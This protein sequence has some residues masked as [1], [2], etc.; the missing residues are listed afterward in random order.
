MARILILDDDPLVLTS[1]SDV[2]QSSGHNVSCATSGQE[3][4]EK[5][6]TAREPFDLVVADVRMSGMDGLQCIHELN[7]RQPHLKSIVITGYASD[8]APG[9]AMDASSSDYLRKPFTAEQLLQSVSR[10]LSAG[11]EESGYQR[12]L[13]QVRAVAQ[14]VGATLSGMEAV[15]DRVFQ[16]YYLGIRAGHLRPS[17]ARSIWEWLEATEWER[18]NAEQDLSLVSKARELKESYEKVGFFCKSPEVVAP[19]QG[20]KEQALSQRE[21]QP[22]YKNIQEGQI[23]CEQLKLAV[24]LRSMPPSELEKAPELLELKSKIW[25]ELRL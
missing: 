7:A 19:S 11:T 5:V 18:L 22:F 20:N 10:C 6:E 25:N 21:F 15:R 16:W 8:D 14:K 9:R 1:L 23:S 13:K 4:I 17:A 12:L 24:Y 2:L 3:A